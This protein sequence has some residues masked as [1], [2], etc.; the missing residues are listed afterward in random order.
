MFLCV[1]VADV[2]LPTVPP[3]LSPWHSARHSPH[4]TLQLPAGSLPAKGK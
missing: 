3:S 1:L 4:R 2:V